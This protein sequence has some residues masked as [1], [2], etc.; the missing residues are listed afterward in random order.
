MQVMH[1]KEIHLLSDQLSETEKFYTGKLG[2]E[3][4]GREKGFVEFAAG[5]TGLI[6]HESRNRS[7]FYHIAFEIP[8]SELER[9]YELAKSKFQIIPVSPG[10]DIADFKNWNAKSFYFYD[11][12]GSILEL[13]CRYDVS[14]RNS[15]HPK[16]IPVCYVSEIGIVSDNVPDL[17]DQLIAQLNTQIFSR[18][19]RQ[20]NF[21]AVGDDHGLFILSQANRE[22]YPTH[23]RGKHFWTKIKVEVNGILHELEF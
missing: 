23:H 16:K 4:T 17:A 10:I 7:P 3:V 12:N 21:T 9:S 18:Q 1:F 2:L 20:K 13:I 22:W 5:S 14:H 11:N 8:P 19:P 15:L 6:F